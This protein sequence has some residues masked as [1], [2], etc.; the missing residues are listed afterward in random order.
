M[1]GNKTINKF[2][3]SKIPKKGTGTTNEEVKV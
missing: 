2:K 1:A 3:D